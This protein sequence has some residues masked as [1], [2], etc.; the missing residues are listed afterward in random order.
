MSPSPRRQ[1]GPPGRSGR[2]PS[3]FTELATRCALVGLAVATGWAVP[4]LSGQQPQSLPS[5]SFTRAGSGTSWL[6]DGAGPAHRHHVPEN[7]WRVTA[8]GTVFLHYLR[9]FGT[10]AG[11]QVGSVNWAMVQAAGP[12]GGADGLLRLRGM[13]SAEPLTVTPRGYPDPLKVTAVYHGEAVTDRAHP[14][15]WLMELAALYERRLPGTRGTAFSLYLAPVGEPAL[16]PVGYEHRPSAAFEPGAPLGHHSQD[17]T[18]ARFG[19]ATVRLF[20]RLLRLEASAFNDRQHAH[21]GAVFAYHDAA[22]DAYA[23]RLTIIPSASWSVS[24]S[25]GY[26]PASGGAHAHDAQHHWG[27]ATLA[28]HPA[29]TTNGGGRS[30]SLALVYGATRPLGA[31]RALPSLLGEA[32]VAWSGGGAVFARVEY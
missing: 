17:E 3:S 16:G 31:S 4:A 8:H 25:Y 1:S 6:P 29:T 7:R 22:L 10:R 5:L 28:T 32:T 19:V 13:A 14:E 21:P 27:I 26:L 24:A 9:T 2:S 12:A 30:W 15:R 11:D 20:P 23:G 18:H